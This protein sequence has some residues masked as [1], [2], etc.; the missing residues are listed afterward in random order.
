MVFKLSQYQIKQKMKVAKKYS[1]QKDYVLIKV[2]GIFEEDEIC[3][4]GEMYD[5]VKQK[6]DGNNTYLYCLKDDMELTLFADLYDFIKKKN[7]SENPMKKGE[8]SVFKTLLNEYCYDKTLN[9]YFPIQEDRIL[10][11]NFL[12]LYSMFIGEIILPPPQVS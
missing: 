8:S 2:N 1:S 3:F 6:F 4:K 7:A 12:S 5:V 11:R 10:Q 9:F